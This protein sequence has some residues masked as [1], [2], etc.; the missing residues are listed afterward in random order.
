[1]AANTEVRMSTYWVILCAFG[2][3]VVPVVYA[4]HEAE[5]WRALPA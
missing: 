2:R 3:I 4:R 5:D 1:M